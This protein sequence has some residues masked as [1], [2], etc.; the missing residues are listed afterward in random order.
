MQGGGITVPGTTWERA[1]VGAESDIT[2]A[3][4]AKLDKTGAEYEESVQ[5]PRAV[6]VI[7]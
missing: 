5:E 4:P 3:R 7:K 6:V 1:P 2:H